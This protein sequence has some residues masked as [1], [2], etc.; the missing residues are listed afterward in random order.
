MS[1]QNPLANMPWWV[2]AVTYVGLPAVILGV[3]MYWQR[4]DAVAQREKIEAQ[5]TTLAVQMVSH[6][7]DNGALLQVAQRICL[8]TAKTQDDRIS[9]LAIHKD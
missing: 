3:V 4:Q 8:N 7:R 9:C 1:S 2:Q 6:V 5:V